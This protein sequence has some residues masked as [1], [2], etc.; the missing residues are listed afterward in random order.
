MPPRGTR[1][2]VPVGVAGFLPFGALSERFYASGVYAVP[3]TRIDLFGTIRL[4][5]PAKLRAELENFSTEADVFFVGEPSDTP[6][7]AERRKLLLRHPSVSLAGVLFGLVWGLPSVLLTRQFDSVDRVVPRR[8]AAERGLDVEPVGRSLV[9]AV[10]D[11]SPMETVLSWF[12]FAVTGLFL[13]SSVALFVGQLLDPTV[14]PGVSPLTLGVCGFVVGFLPAA[15]L[16]RDTLSARNEAIAD[17]VERVVSS[18]DDVEVG[19][20]V[21]GYTHVPGVE[22]QLQ[23]RDVEVGRT[24]S[25]KFLRRNS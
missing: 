2:G 18:G 10:G 5:R 11:V 6:T 15:F 9:G 7:T 20:L 14:F 19:C 16:A 24:H 25:S 17:N 4:D 8:V 3:V 12:Q 23:E 21:V 22:Q 1:T 13:L